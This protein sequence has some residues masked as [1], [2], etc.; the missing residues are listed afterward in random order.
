MKRGATPQK[1]RRRLRARVRALVWLFGA[2]LILLVLG[3]LYAYLC[4]YYSGELTLAQKISSADV[5]RGFDFGPV[6]MREGVPGRYYLSAVL[7]EVDG[8]YWQTSFE[9]LDETKMP[10]YRQ[11]E[12]HIIGDFE[13]EPG[14]QTSYVKNFTLDKE[15]GYY[16]FRYT[17]VNGVYDANK[18]AG[19]V[20]EFAVRQ[21]VITGPVFWAPAGAALLAGIILLILG[22]GLVKALNSAPRVEEAPMEQP[23]L[24]EDHPLARRK[25]RQDRF[26]RN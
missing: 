20:V 9:V 6:Y 21:G 15:S 13:F 18:T 4:Y 19:P 25:W 16:Y 11:D 12:L 23:E 14:Q 3:P 1:S 5:A 24:V 2:G 22:F 8:D 7:P 10:V 17:A 26:G